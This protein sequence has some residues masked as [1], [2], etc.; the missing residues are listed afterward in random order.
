MNLLL[1]VGDSPLPLGLTIMGLRPSHVSFIVEDT[2]APHVTPQDTV[3]LIL[4]CTEDLGHAV[5]SHDTIP[6]P[7]YDAAAIAAAVDQAMDSRQ[8]R[9]HLGYS[10]GSPTMAL[11][12]LQ[13][14]TDHQTAKTAHQSPADGEPSPQANAWYVVGQRLVS[15][16]GQEIA[17]ALDAPPS[18]GTIVALHGWRLTGKS[19]QALPG[20]NNAEQDEARKTLR[21]LAVAVAPTERSNADERIDEATRTLLRA[22]LPPE[23]QLHGPVTVQRGNR[24][25]EIDAVAVRGLN[26]ILFGFS[27]YLPARDQN[28]FPSRY[29]NGCL[30]QRK[31]DAFMLDL[32]AKVL[33]GLQA[34]SVYVLYPTAVAPGR[35]CAKLPEQNATELCQ[36]IT[37]DLASTGL[38][39]QGQLVIEA[40]EI[41]GVQGFFRAWLEASR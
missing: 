19:G 20:V 27:G 33:G 29:L 24:D 13:R 10:G 28:K 9:W 1:T 26:L 14:W 35:G 15:V 17:I 21:G 4:K 7:R 16:D 12:A 11:T 30:A 31:E 6:V 32:Q 18:L 3:E 41:T 23:F 38:P 40:S 39:R 37:D 25:M 22:I 2:S 36:S 8:G 5:T 34:R